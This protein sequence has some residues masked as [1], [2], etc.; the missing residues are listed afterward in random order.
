MRALVT[1]SSAISPRLYERFI[2]RAQLRGLLA[3]H[4]VQGE[5]YLAL[6][7]LALTRADHELLCHLTSIFS[8]AFERAGRSLAASV[9]ILEEIGFPWVAAELLAVEEPRTPVVGRFDFVQDETGRW[10]LLEF[11]ADT[12]S[13]VREAI[14][15]DALVHAL[16]PA[17]RT[18]LTV[19]GRLA[20]TIAESFC[21]ALQGLAPGSTLGLVTSAG[22]LEDLSQMAFTQELL[23]EPLARYG[24]EVVLGDA[25][26]LGTSRGRL[27]L[28]GR[29]VDALYRYLPY[30]TMLG[31]HQFAAI[32]DAVA[33]GRT[34]LLNGLFGLLLQ[35]KGTLAWLWAHRN[36]PDLTE[37][38][39][40]AIRTHLPPTWMIDQVPASADWAQLVVKQVF[41]REG[42]EV[43]FGDEL[44]PPAWSELVRRRTY[45]A[46]A[47]VHVQE[48]EAVVPTSLGME[49][50][51][52]SATV[53]GF[54]VGGRWAGYYSR[55][56]GRII[57]SRAKWLATFVESDADESER[58]A[59]R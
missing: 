31:T 27:T 38:E 35:N 48:I 1:D 11:N 15:A 41:G 30:E 54:A 8:S 5:P 10:W 22:E 36:D 23:R 29:G 20:S 14:V 3:D 18:L 4:L 16:L 21:A 13:G 24:L 46:Q 53:G 43:F 56:G 52:G 32:A 40:S 58:S 17:A 9:P 7:A 28:C 49:K 42:A 12:P 2:R 44:D 25:H 57:T 6:N 39:R 51:R 37:A 33:H 26:N 45:V 55:F 19:N 34:L 50:Q 47:R 59:S